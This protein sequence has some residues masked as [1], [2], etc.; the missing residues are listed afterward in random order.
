MNITRMIVAC[1]CLVLSVILLGISTGVANT[2]SYYGNNVWNDV[3]LRG[4]GIA[5]GV[6]GLFISIWL[7]LVALELEFIK[8][9]ED[10]KILQFVVI[11]FVAFELIMSIATLGVS[12]S[13]ITSIRNTNCHFSPWAGRSG[14]SVPDILNACCAFAVFMIIA[15]GVQLF[16][17]IRQFANGPEDSSGAGKAPSAESSA[18]AH[19]TPNP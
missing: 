11:A 9:M 6:F 15:W 13:D 8:N 10:S 1:A 2:D 12:A 17:E 19:R 4:L 7:I 5:T 16:L 14:C 18:A 3:N